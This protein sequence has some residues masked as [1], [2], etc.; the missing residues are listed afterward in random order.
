[1]A[2]AKHTP[3][4]TPWFHPRWPTPDGRTYTAAERTDAARLI[5]DHK[6]AY[7]LEVKTDVHGRRIYQLLSSDRRWYSGYFIVARAAIAKATGS[8]S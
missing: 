6:R 7:T 4:A 2:D 3:K 5:R 1:M 8:A